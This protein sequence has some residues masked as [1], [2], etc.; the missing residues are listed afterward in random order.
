MKNSFLDKKTEVLENMRGQTAE[1][2]LLN[3]LKTDIW[4][5]KE[6]IKKM[7]KTK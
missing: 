6:W 3:T 1:K 4:P 5:I 2:N 7:I